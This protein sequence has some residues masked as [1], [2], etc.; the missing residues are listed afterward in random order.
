MDR[1]RIVARSAVAGPDSHPVHAS[2]PLDRRAAMNAEAAGATSRLRQEFDRTR[3]ADV[4]LARAQQV[5]ALTKE[6]P[7]GLSKRALDPSPTVRSKGGWAPHDVP[8]RGRRVRWA[9]GR[10]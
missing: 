10:P 5:Q 7:T 2:P 3:R 6:A 8:W 1:R 9:Q 4:P